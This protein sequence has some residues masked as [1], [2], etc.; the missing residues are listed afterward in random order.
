[1]PNLPGPAERAAEAKKKTSKPKVSLTAPKARGTRADGT[2]KGT[3]AAPRVVT[4]RKGD[5][6]SSIAKANNTT[7]A[8][9]KKMNPKFTN[10][11]KY[12]GGNRIFT[13]TTVRVRKG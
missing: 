9:V 3:F 7:V 1:M 12:Q 10:D 2:K 5:T 8:A 4:V 6:L 13:G 11:A